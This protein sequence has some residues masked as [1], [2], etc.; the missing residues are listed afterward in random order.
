MKPG[1]RSQASCGE[2]VEAVMLRDLECIYCDTRFTV[3]I[4]A[5]YSVLCPCCKAG[6]LFEGEHGYGPVT[7]C[8]IYLGSDILG[9]V[10]ASGADY[11]LKLGKEVIKLSQTGMEAIAEA[12]GILRN[13]LGFSPPDERTD[14]AIR[15]GA[16]CFYGDWFGRPYDNFH[17]VIHACYDARMEILEI[18]FERGSVCSCISLKTYQVQSGN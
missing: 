4:S 15:G 14:I 18:L 5:N 7:P 3:E 6:V 8:R 9:T 13:R 17:K 2:V 11:W 10:E 12:E 1:R 16:L